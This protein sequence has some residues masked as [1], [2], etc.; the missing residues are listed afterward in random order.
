MRAEFHPAA[1]VEV[2]DAQAWYEELSPVAASAFLREL[3]AAINTAFVT[4]RHGIPRSTGALVESSSNGFRSRS[5]NER[6]MK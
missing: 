5:T 3:S 6:V 4:H 2:E 1:S